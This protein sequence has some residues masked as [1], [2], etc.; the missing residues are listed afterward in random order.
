MVLALVV[1]LVSLAG[2]A[3]GSSM[4]PGLAGLL[5]AVALSAVL[6]VAVDPRMSRV[7][8]FGFLLGMEVLLHLVFVVSSEHHVGGGASMLV[9]STASVL[10]HVAAAVAAVAVLRH[11]DRVLLSWSALLSAAFGAPSLQLPSIAAR[12]VLVAGPWDAHAVGADAQFSSHS[13]R[14]PPVT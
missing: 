10:G 8:L 2:H 11:G 1:V 9:P 12:P 3:A 5:L 7:R 6:A 13:R 14:G 4:L